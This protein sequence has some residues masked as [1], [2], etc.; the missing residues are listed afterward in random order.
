MCT[1]ASSPTQWHA[2]FDERR[3]RVI[4]HERMPRHEATQLHV[5]AQQRARSCVSPHTHD[6][7]RAR[8]CVL[9]A[10]VHAASTHQHAAPID[11]ESKRR[12]CATCGG[13]G[14]ARGPAARS[15]ASGE[16]AESSAS[17]EPHESAASPSSESAGIT[18]K[19][20]SFRPEEQE[21]GRSETGQSVRERASE[22]EAK[23]D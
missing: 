1:N 19:L 12:T 18:A 16:A 7:Q 13:D 20:I 14:N 4:A 11:S 9:Y 21:G 8:A 6:K 22:G 3:I 23:Q 15:D 2:V 10:R 17:G 5:A